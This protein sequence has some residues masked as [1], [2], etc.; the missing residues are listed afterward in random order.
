MQIKLIFLTGFKETLSLDI[1]LDHRLHCE[2]WHGCDSEF[3]RQNGC[4]N[5]TGGNQGGAA[6]PPPPVFIPCSTPAS[7]H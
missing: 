6:C 1:T 2:L 4:M 5:A 7:I 3:C